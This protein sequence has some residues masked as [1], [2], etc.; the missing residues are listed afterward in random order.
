MESIYFVEIENIKG[1]LF[2]LK[3]T[4]S[5]KFLDSLNQ[6]QK[7]NYKDMRL[8]KKMND[9]KNKVFKETKNSFFS[10]LT[11]KQIENHSTLERAKQA[12]KSLLKVEMTLAINN[13]LKNE[14]QQ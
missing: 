14:I 1:V 2:N 8:L 4:E 3:Q 5:K 12:Y 11:E 6:E 10:S 9:V 7:Q 13:L